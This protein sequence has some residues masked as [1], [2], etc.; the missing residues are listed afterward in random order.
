MGYSND[1][2]YT[3]VASLD[4]T[5]PVCKEINEETAKGMYVEL[6]ASSSPQLLEVLSVG[7]CCCRDEGLLD[8][9]C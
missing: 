9:G 1:R 2:V 5:D 8:C 4:P 3:V 6:V 7:W